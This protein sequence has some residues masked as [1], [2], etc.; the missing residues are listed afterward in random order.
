MDS[1][2]FHFE[3]F[4]GLGEVLGLARADQAG[5]VLQFSTRDALFGVLKSPTR[6]LCIGYED[7]LSV[8]FRSGFLWMTPHIELRVRN[9]DVLGDLPESS[10]GRVCLSLRWRDRRDAQAFAADLDQL[11]AHRRILQLDRALD[12]MGAPR[13]SDWREPPPQPAC[14][15]EST[16]PTES[17]QTGYQSRKRHNRVDYDAENRLST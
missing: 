16:L 8:R 11:R 5:L 6:N 1:V 9:L 13:P 2:P 17:A 14:L 12:A 3:A 4:G 7:L 10:E 15:A